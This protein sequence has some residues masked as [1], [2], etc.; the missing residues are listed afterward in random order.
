MEDIAKA[1][2]KSRSTLYHYFKN[3]TEVLDAVLIDIFS[4]TFQLATKHIDKKHTLKA[5]L[6]SFQVLKL[7]DLKLK[8]VEFDSLVKDIREQ[9]EILIKVTNVM[10]S[11]EITLVHQI[12]TWGIENGD[13]AK[14]DAAEVDFLARSLVLAMR[15]LEIDALLYGNMVMEISHL[16]RLITIL[17]KGL[18]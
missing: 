11:E 16:E 13:V 5:N 9:P 2:G 3:K 17:A 4:E 1:C 12:L 8:L 15:N 14:I 6:L 7:A 10:V 18:K